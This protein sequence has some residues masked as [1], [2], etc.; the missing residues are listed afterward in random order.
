M[1][2]DSKSRAREAFGVALRGIS[3]QVRN[4][5]K[6][7]LWVQIPWCP[8]MTVVRDAPLLHSRAALASGTAEVPLPTNSH[9]TA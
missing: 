7:F 6:G 9:R 2:A 4:G 1:R 3:H 8:V 5:H